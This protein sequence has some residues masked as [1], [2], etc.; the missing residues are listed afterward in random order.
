MLIRNL[1][2]DSVL[3][4][5]INNGDVLSKIGTLKNYVDGRSISDF[6]PAN[7]DLIMNGFNIK[8]LPPYD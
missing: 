8:E 1:D 7:K 3:K 2:G 5:A 4:S 6:L